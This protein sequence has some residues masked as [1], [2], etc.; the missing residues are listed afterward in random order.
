M[1]DNITIALNA[2]LLI[3]VLTYMYPLK[4]MVSGWMLHGGG[5]WVLV[6]EYMNKKLN[7]KN[8]IFKYGFASIVS[9]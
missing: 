9:S 5:P 3:T 8:N 7:D 4:F 1:H 2:A 6:Q